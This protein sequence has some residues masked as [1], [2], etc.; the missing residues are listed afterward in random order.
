[1][2]HLPG[3]S[4][5]ID[6]TVL[7]VGAG[8]GGLAAAI[9]LRQAGVPARVLERAPHLGEVGAGLGLWAN[10]VLVLDR[11]G[12]GEEIRG[13]GAPLTIAEICSAH[14]TVLSRLDLRRVLPDPRAASYVV[15]RA[16]LHAALARRLPP[17]LVETGAEVLDVLQDARGGANVLLADGRSVRGSLVIGADGIRSAVRRSLW[18]EHALR[19]S[20]QTCYRGIAPL[21][22]A[23][24]HVLREV[25]GSGRRAAVCPLG[26]GRVYW[27]AAVNAPADQSD[28]PERRREILGEL[29]RGWPHGVPEAI[30]A[31]EGAILRNDLV[32]REP[33]RHWSRGRATLLGDAAHPMLPNLGQGACTAL[34][35]ALVLA[36]SVRR[37]GATP[38]ALRAYEAARIPRTTR[39]VR[40]SWSFGGPARWSA[41]WAVRLRETLIRATPSAV[42]AGAIRR[43]VGYDAS[44]VIGGV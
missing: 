11:L 36:Q 19:Y 9:A 8:I 37:H 26:D 1:M 21:D 22:V 29:F 34:E 35:D 20:G 24:P 32:D 28:E 31:S 41:P 23:D 44:A 13:L 18:G 25:Q 17:G 10:A 5:A 43:H 16:D 30:A 40:E 15:H 6:D 3:R 38:D 7:I 12:A 42:L 39:I 27:W 4:G 14:G 2:D 33:L